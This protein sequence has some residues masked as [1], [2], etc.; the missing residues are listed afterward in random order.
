MSWL[1]SPVCTSYI[2]RIGENFN[3]FVGFGEFKLDGTEE[4]KRWIMSLC[5]YP[6]A[7]GPALT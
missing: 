5:R 6:Y 7:K 2:S 1:K 4:I 3:A